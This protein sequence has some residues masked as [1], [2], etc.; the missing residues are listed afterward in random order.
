[1]EAVVACSTKGPMKSPPCRCNAGRARLANMQY[2]GTSDVAN[3]KPM[4]AHSSEQ[5]GFFSIHKIPFIE[6]AHGSERASA[7]KKAGSTQGLDE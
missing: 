4:G 3:S 7:N 1:M 6:S 5:V 2:F